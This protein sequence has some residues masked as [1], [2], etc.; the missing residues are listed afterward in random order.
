MPIDTIL[1]VIAAVAFVLVTIGADTKSVNML[2]LGLFCLT[3][4]LLV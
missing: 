4:S 3:L 1:Y 2:G